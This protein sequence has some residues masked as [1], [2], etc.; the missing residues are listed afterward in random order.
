MSRIQLEKI[1]L[2]RNENTYGPA[3]ACLEVLKEA[4]KKLFACYT[5]AY[6]R[7][8]KSTLS[9]RLATDFNIDEER[10]ILGYGAEDI[11]K[12]LVQCY[13]G[14]GQKL[15]V[16]AYS[17]WYYKE[18][19]SEVGGINIEYPLIKGDDSFY[20]DIERM[21]QLIEL[22]KPTYCYLDSIEYICKDDFGNENKCSK[23]YRCPLLIE[24]IVGFGTNKILRCRN[25]FFCKEFSIIDK[26]KKIIRPQQCIDENGL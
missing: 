26:I 5:D 3:P 22:E 7:G 17:W 25:N 8:V 14:P 11:L 15:M 6:K 2:D 10:V 19:A 24:E 1:F 13:L 9:E 4:D 20:Y 18:I 23:E 21:L 16:P 12:Q